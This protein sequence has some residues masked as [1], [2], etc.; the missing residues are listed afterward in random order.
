M[1]GIGYSSTA[2]GEL[3]ALGVI[4]EVVMFLFMHRLLPR[5]GARRVLIAS[6]AIAVVRWLLVGLMPE[7]LPLVLLAQLM[8]AAIV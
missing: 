2:I 7:S 1:E 4:A 5:W 3:W 6:L 8:H